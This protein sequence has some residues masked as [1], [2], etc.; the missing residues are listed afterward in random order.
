MFSKKLSRHA[1]AVVTGAGSGIGRAFALEI[2]KRGGRVVCSDIKP[3]T[4]EETARMITAEG[5]K[6]LALQCDVSDLKSVEVLAQ[7]AERWL[8]GPVDLVI[9]NAGICDMASVSAMTVEQFEEHLAINTVGPFLLFKGLETFLVKN[10][11]H[12]ISILSTAAH[13][14]YPNV[15]GYN[16]SKFG[17]LGLIE[18]LKKEWK[19]SLHQK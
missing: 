14:G 5:G 19:D 6:A 12:I 7:E 18:S 17:Q 15:S 16:A 13:Y 11:T 3:A 2:A 10:E 4:A 8:E 9:N 1:S